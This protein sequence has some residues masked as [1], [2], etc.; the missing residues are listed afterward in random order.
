MAN[1][2]ETNKAAVGDAPATAAGTPVEEGM[3]GAASDG[4]AAATETAGRGETPAALRAAIYLDSPVRLRTA[5]VVRRLAEGGQLKGPSL[6]MTGD[7]AMDAALRAGPELGA[8]LSR[9][10][11][12]QDETVALEAENGEAGAEVV[13]DLRALPCETGTLGGAVVANALEYADNPEKLMEELHR[14]L[15]PKTKVV[16]HARRRR[17]SLVGVLRR[18]TGLTDPT[19]AAVNDGFTPSELF[20]ALKE[21]FDV[22]ESI[23]YGRFF[24][25]FTEWM[26][27]LFAGVMPQTCEAGALDPAVLRRARTVYRVFRPAFAL[28][29]ALDA[30]CFFLPTHHLAVRAKRRL[31]WAP[32]IA[33]R[34]RDGRTLA[35]AVLGG[36]IGTAVGQ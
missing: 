11:V 22:E 19:R 33:P 18:W 4:E 31:L 36:K 30:L 6:L 32:R 23:G 9:T 29:K 16:L 17:R 12:Y 10:L 28:A 1:E 13:R 27:E 24:V 21:G 20:E 7:D 2:N 35:D 8:V 5:A 15:A 3:A 34:L 26:A 14:A 25:E